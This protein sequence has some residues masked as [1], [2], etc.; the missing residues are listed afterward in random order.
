MAEFSKGEWKVR[1]PPRELIGARIIET[2]SFI[3]ATANQAK[4]ANLISAA[5]DMHEALLSALGAI[6]VLDNTKGW[7]QEISK[8][9]QKALAKA[10]GK[11]VGNGTET[12]AN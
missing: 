2:E 11:E 7:V 8:V 5:P 10:D 6:A 1:K 3:I 9:I 4:D 12:R